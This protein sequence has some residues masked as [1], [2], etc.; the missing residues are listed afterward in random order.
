M[1]VEKV[2]PHWFPADCPI[3]IYVTASSYQN[4]IFKILRA[5]L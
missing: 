1:K 4:K 3:F 2:N 5:S